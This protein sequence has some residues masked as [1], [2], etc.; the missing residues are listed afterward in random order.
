M[1]DDDDLGRHVGQ[2]GSC[3][4]HRGFDLGGLVGGALPVV[5]GQVGFLAHV[6]YPIE[7]GRF[8]DR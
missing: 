4:G 1:V 7:A 8:D 3:L 6:R 2:P 5:A